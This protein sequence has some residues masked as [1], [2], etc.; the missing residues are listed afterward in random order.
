[1]SLKILLV[2]DH[3]INQKMATA[4]LKKLGFSVEVAN[5]GQEAV[6]M[7]Q[8]N[9]YDALIM[10]IEMPVMDGLEATK[11]IRLKDKTTPIIA[12]SGNPNDEYAKEVKDIGMN[13]CLKKP[14]D[15]E[16]LMSTLK[17]VISDF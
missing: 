16:V 4:L 8:E 3:I 9:R 5:N 17:A 2:E 15:I 13:G 1:M 6:S 10:D 7:H 12:L 14:I 11:L